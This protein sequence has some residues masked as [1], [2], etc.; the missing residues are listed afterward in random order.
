MLQIQYS[1]ID[2]F[3]WVSDSVWLLPKHYTT[4]YLQTIK[5]W[6]GYC[7]Q[8]LQII[9]RESSPKLVGQYRMFHL[10]SLIACDAFI[11]IPIRSNSVIILKKVVWVIYQLRYFRKFL[12]SQWPQQFSTFIGNSHLVCFYKTI[13]RKHL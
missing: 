11:T 6:K 9:E 13:F 5:L 1:E 8:C 7:K 4:H 2:G 10:Y 3:R 12:H